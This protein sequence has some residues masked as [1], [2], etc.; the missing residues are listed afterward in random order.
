MKRVTKLLRSPVTTLALFGAAAVLLLTSTIGGARAAL[1]YFSE[2]YTTRVQMYDIGVTLCENGAAVSWR[3]YGASAD[4][5]WQEATGV[6]LGNLLTDAGDES[7]RLGKTYPEALSA[8]NSGS[9]DEYVRVTVY[10]YW[11]DKFGNKLQSLDPSLIDLH[12]T[13]GEAWLIDEAA[14]TPERTVL[15][16]RTVLPAT[17]ENGEQLA[18]DDPRRRTPALT[19]TLTIEEGALK[20]AT[21]ETVTEE[22]RD[23]RTYRTVTTTYDYDGVTFVV[24][25]EVDAVQTHNAEAAIRSAWGRSVTVADGEVRLD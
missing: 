9:I 5:T 22:V 7:L 21:T 1:T 18:E 4:G 13:P 15:Y 25:A 11:T 3:D 19:D 2:F 6:L 24:E 17:D 20:A 23:G 16:Y 14:S 10:R 8:E 12:F